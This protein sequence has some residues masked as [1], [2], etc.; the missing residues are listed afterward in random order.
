MSELYPDLPDLHDLRE[1]AIEARDHYAKVIAEAQVKLDRAEEYLAALDGGDRKPVRTP[2][3]PSVSEDAYRLV[4]T[5][6]ADHAY[7][8]ISTLAAEACFSRSHVGQI[9][10]KAQERDHVVIKDGKSRTMRFQL[11]DAGME[12][13]TQPEDKPVTVT[14]GNGHDRK[15]SFPELDAALR[16]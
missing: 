15:L 9:M 1:L 16:S 4:L 2:K 3:V 13:L 10:K 8:R 6:L 7:A 14:V 11:T 5:K 12:Y